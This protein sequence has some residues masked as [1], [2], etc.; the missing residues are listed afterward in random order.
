ME[1]I[2]TK[3]VWKGKFMSAVEITYRDANGAVRTWEAVARVGIGGIV[4]M[5]AV[6]PGRTILL[7]KQFRPPLGRDV[8]ELPAGLVDPGESMEDAAQRE[9]IEETGWKAGH[10]DFLAEGPMS[11]GASTEIL[12]AYLC[13][14]LVNVG[15]SGGDD[16][17]IIEVIEV[18][19]DGV[20]EY[21]RDVQAQGTFVDL[22][23]YGL[24]ELAKQ[25]LGR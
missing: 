13:T 14:D 12:R 17:E 24:V 9:L 15:R 19:L 10:L 25:K 3:T 23:V 11:T 5:A 21:L 8:I 4:V 18:P 7:E 2:N 20:Q 22:K 1:I 16:N 6:T